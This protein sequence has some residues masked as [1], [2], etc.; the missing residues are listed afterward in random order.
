MAKKQR[1][2]PLRNF[3]Y[4]SR[5]RIGEYCLKGFVW[6]LPWIPRRLLAAITAV[7]S[8]L[9][10]ALL[11]RYRTRME[12]NLGMAM[13]E[14]LPSPTER[15]ALA[16]KAWRN[17]A[18]GVLETTCAVHDT[19]E[20]ILSAVAIQGEE[21]LRRALQKAR[22]VIALSAHLGNFPMIGIRLAAAGY[23]FNVVVKHPRDRRFARLTDHYRTVVGITTIAAKPRREAVRQILKALRR[24][25]VVLMIADEFKSGGVQVEFLGRRAPAP[26]GPATLA[27]RT[28]APVLPMFVTR[29]PKDRLTLLVG[30]ELDLAK[31]DDLQEAVD[32]NVALFTGQLEAMVRRHPDQWNWL[33]FHRNGRRQRS[34]M[35][36]PAPDTHD[37]PDHRSS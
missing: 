15:R 7:A 28:G 31:R 34:R 17:F 20:E 5:Y 9:T 6:L 21:N 10:F 23:P 24:N 33:G 13:G 25:E 1:Q 12:E 14:E 35:G 8:R 30:P 3:F 11:W 32:V 22:G 18:Q 26:R 2:F 27:L 16:L 19:T 37:F 29:D 4:W 36:R